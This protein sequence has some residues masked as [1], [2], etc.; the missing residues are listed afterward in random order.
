MKYTCLVF[1]EGGKDKKFLIALI[2]LDKFKFHTKKWNFNYDNASGSSPKIILKQCKKATQGINYDL[3]ICFIDLDKLKHDYPKNWQA[4]K[5]KLENEYCNFIIIWQEDNL[6]DEFIKVIGDQC[7]N[8]HRLNTIAR[9]EVNKFINSKF[10]KKILKVINDREIE[11]EEQEIF[12]KGNSP[13]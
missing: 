6:E 10:W 2:D 7:C 11:L 9:K 12:G 3:I 1:G 8:K 13:L 5:K 4:E